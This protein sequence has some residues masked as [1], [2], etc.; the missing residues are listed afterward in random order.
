MAEIVGQKR[1]LASFRGRS[2]V[3]FM[4]KPVVPIADWIAEIDATLAHSVGFFT[5]R[6]VVLDLSAVDLSHSAT[7]HL[8]DSL[9]SRG[10]R[11]LGLEGLDASRVGP[12]LP[13]LLIGGRQCVIES[14]A[15]EPLPQAKPA[16]SLLLESPVRSGQSVVFADG[17]VTI[18]GSVGSGAEIVA[19][20]SIHI[21]GTLRGRAM[22]GVSGNSSAR[23]YCHKLEAELLA[24]DGYYQTVEDMD[25]TLRNRP[26]QA[27]LDG[28]VMKITALN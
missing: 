8:I 21:Y 18:L 5:G 9:E 12:G 3:A 1:P 10:I 6:P 4:F 16:K 17:D 23:I 7:V 26:A 11:V 28:D 25:V 22:A 14:Q 19:G 13:P 27:W 15:A 2:Y 20:G 24:I